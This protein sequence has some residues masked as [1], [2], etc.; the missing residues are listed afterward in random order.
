MHDGV[1]LLLRE[2]L[3]ELVGVG[4]ARGLSAGMSISVSADEHTEER[5]VPRMRVTCG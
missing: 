2:V 5:G 4:S 1:L 3:L